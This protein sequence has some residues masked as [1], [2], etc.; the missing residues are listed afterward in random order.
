MISYAQNGEDV[1]LRRAFP[2]NKGFYIDVGAAFPTLDSV[3][4]YFY[5][6][7]WSGINIEPQPQIYH[8]LNEQRQRDINLNCAIGTKIGKQK[9]MIF[10]EEWGWAT[11][12][13]E[14]SNL[15]RRKKVKI[16]VEVKKLDAVLEELKLEVEIDF[17][18]ID[19]EGNEGDVLKSF[20]LGKW[21][22]KTLII[23]V[24]TQGK[25]GDAKK[26]WER[27]IVQRGYKFAVFDGLNRF[28]VRKD[29][30]EIL[31]KLSAPV[32]C[33]DS[34]YPQRYLSQ[35]P[36]EIRLQKIFEWRSRGKDVTDFERFE[37][38]YDQL[39]KEVNYKYEEGFE[40]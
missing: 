39:V 31:K 22:P 20:N 5:D 32:N 6:L 14:L 35:I 23:E 34:Y 8:I 21:Q 11:M 12:N 10:P 26:E 38:L 16:E 7:G 36:K 40:K 4:K 1:L 2:T 33:L 15:K 28:Y 19:V 3:T 27:Y 9:L 30:K 24:I 25:E 18:K 13:S 29:S 37:V 17:V